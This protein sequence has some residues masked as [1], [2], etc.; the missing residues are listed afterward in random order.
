MDKFLSLAGETIT[1]ILAF[2]IFFWVM[3]KYAWPVVLGAIDERQKEIQDGFEE[4]KKL[5][6]DAAEAHQRYE[7]KLRNIEQEARTQI[8]AAVTEGKQIAAEVTDK[9]RDEAKVIIE[10]AKNSIELEIKS[11][12]KKLRDEIVSLTL[13]ATEKLINERMTEAKDRELVGSFISEIENKQP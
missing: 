3:K 10:K 1:A 13:H 4:I 6:D 11:S 9:A 2:S 5:Q 8:Q 7:E 12:R